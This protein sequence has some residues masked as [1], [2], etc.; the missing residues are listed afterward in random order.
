MRYLDI[1]W[2]ARGLCVAMTVLLG[3]VSLSAQISR[4]KDLNVTAPGVTVTGNAN[5][6]S[7]AWTQI[8]GATRYDVIRHELTINPD[9]TTGAATAWV[10]IASVTAGAYADVL[11]KPSVL[12]EYRVDA[13]LRIGSTV[14]SNPVRYAAPAFTTPTNVTVTGANMQATVSWAPAAGVSGYN[15]WRR[16]VHNDGSVGGLL[17]RT[18]T[19]VTGT[20]FND[21]LPVLGVPYEYQVIAFDPSGANWPSTWTRY[22]APAPVALT[23]PTVAIAGAG[24]KAL[25]QWSPVTGAA[26]YRVSRVQLD[27]KGVPMGSATPLAPGPTGLALTDILPA[28]SVAYGY[29]VTAVSADMSSSATSPLVTFMSP[30]FMTPGTIVAAGG[31]GKVGLTWCAVSAVAG[32]QVWR[33]TLRTDGSTADLSQRT[34]QMV[35]TPSF[36]DVISTANSIYEYQVVAVGLDGRLWPSAWSRFAAG[37][38]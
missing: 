4:T 38:W 36:V 19:P 20:T 16:E 27:V 8:T 6:A 32:Y 29:S 10:T 34:S 12:Y 25:V 21:A 35:Q 18:G 3:P 22:A 26:S 24:D 23:A 15:V 2:T 7:V 31:G 11:P 17:Q 14:S 37:S 9:G 1:N 5:Q 28:P 13:V 33:R 30:P